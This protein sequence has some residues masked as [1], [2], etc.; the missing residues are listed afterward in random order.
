MPSYIHC[1]NL[2]VGRFSYNGMNPEVER[3]MNLEKIHRA[4]KSSGEME[5]DIAD[6]EMAVVALANKMNKNVTLNCAI[7]NG[8][9]T[10]E[11]ESD[12]DGTDEEWEGILKSVNV[13]T[14]RS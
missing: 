13:K 9:V 6:E 1:K 3:M 5:K 7:D 10:A 11:C 14:K 4:S 12:N 2:I 8:Q